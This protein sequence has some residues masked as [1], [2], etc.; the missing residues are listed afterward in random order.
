MVESAIPT[1][2]WRSAI[3]R[4]VTCEVER[5]EGVGRDAGE[6]IS[7]VH[8]ERA[9][10]VEAVRRVRQRARQDAWPQ[11]PILAFARALVAA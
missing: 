3:R 7:D 10:H 4:L 8:A 5:P 9:Q 11:R 1:C 6:A 2:W